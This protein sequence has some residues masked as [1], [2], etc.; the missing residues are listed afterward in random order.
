[1]ALCKMLHLHAT[2]IKVSVYKDQ[3][4]VNMHSYRSSSL[5]QQEVYL[6]TYLYQGELMSTNG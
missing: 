1:M 2:C 5:L 6:Y 3:Y 4:Q